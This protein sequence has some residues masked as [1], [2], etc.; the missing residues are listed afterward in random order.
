MFEVWITIANFHYPST[1][2]G[3]SYSKHFLT[4]YN[5]F[6]R[7]QDPLSHFARLFFVKN[8][9]LHFDLKQ[10]ENLFLA[11][12]LQALRFQS[13]NKKHTAELIPKA[14]LFTVRAF[15]SQ[16]LFFCSSSGV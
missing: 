6:S 7:T 2:H 9:M 5:F 4:A 10:Q 8:G 15:L 13:F 12:M 3:T 11:G 14:C 16:A 1:L